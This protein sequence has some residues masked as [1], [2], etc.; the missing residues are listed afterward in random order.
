M[1]DKELL[2]KLND[3]TTRL[4]SVEDVIYWAISAEQ[5]G[6]EVGSRVA[7][8][9]FGIRRR[10]VRGKAITRIGTVLSISHGLG[11]KVR[12]DGVK[13]VNSYHHGFLQLVGE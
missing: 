5:R 3:I 4:N 2:D 9:P 10:I 7:I 11:I 1:S 12:W 13:T 6:F 8:S